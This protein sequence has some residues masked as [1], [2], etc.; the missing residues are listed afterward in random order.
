MYS[1]RTLLSALVIMGSASAADVDFLSPHAAYATGSGPRT[2]AIGALDGNASN[3]LV[4]GNGTGNSLLVLFN[5]GSGTFGSPLV[6]GVPGNPSSVA[7]VDLNGDGKN[8]VVAANQITGGPVSVFLGNGDGTFQT[9]VDTPGTYSIIAMRVA[10]MDGDG[11]LDVIASGQGIAFFKGNGTGGFVGVSN[12]LT[13]GACNSVTVGDLND[14]GKIDIATTRNGK[15]ATLLGN[16]DG[17]FADPLEWATGTTN[18]SVGLGDFDGDGLNDLAQTDVNEATTGI[19]VVLNQGDGV[20]GPPARFATGRQPKSLMV[21]DLDADGHLDLVCV[22]VDSKSIGILRGKGDGTFHPHIGYLTGASPYVDAV[23]DLDGNGSLDVATANSTANTVSVLR[24]G[25]GAAPSGVTTLTTNLVSDQ[26]ARL[27][28]TTPLIESY[29]PLTRYDLR[30]MIG[31]MTPGDF[32]SATAISPAPT[33]E[34]TGI[35]SQFVVSSLLPN[36][37]YSLA[38]EVHD[39][40]D[41]VSPLSNIITFTTAAT[42]ALPPSTPSLSNIAY[43][44]T[45]TTSYAVLQWYAPGDDG[46]V[47]VATSYNLRMSTDPITDDTSFGAATPVLTVAP[48]PGGTREELTVNGLTAGATYYF[49]MTTTDE[50]PLTSARSATLTVIPPITDGILPGRIT[51][52]AVVAATATTVTLRWTAKGDDG[53]RGGPATSFDVRWADRS[54]NE[55]IFYTMGTAVVGEPAPAV[56]GTVQEFVVT[57]LTPETLYYFATAVADEVPNTSAI[58]NLV[59]VTTAA[60]STGGGGSGGGGGGGG[61]GCG[62]GAGLAALLALLAMALTVMRTSRL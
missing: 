27:T 19:V 51:D 43:G 49:A 34:P 61:G 12:V 16:G 58:S 54:M 31:T 40:F 4:I 44:T 6:L 39:A 41:R 22:N 11:K 9:R 30:I 10:D 28:W 14:D 62:L 56:A 7:V 8:D 48:Q 52:L 36:T 18:L 29:G 24:Q 2:V 35:V 26:Y 42:D 60:A 59:S 13:S 21:D 32:A 15:L 33:V 47:G 53:L 1:L 57:G 5:D 46:V 3:D 20:F 25:T 45:G 17:S 37:T 23:G 38:M 50:V 55:G